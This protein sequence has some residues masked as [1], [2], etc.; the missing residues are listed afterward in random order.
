M[1]PGE[2]PLKQNTPNRMLVFMFTSPKKVFEYCRHFW[3]SLFE[4]ASLTKKN[5]KYITNRML[6]LVG[7]HILV[8]LHA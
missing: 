6:H 5:I 1:T 3:P 7:L 4:V 8:A 2:S